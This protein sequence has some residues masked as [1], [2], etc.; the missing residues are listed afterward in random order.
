MSITSPSTEFMLRELEV[1]RTKRAF[2]SASGWCESLLMFESPSGLSY[3]VARLASGKRRESAPR[4][5]GPR[6]AGNGHRQIAKTDPR[7]HR[8]QG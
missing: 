5:V 3:V 7:Q 1:L 6:D 2:L 8:C 4:Q